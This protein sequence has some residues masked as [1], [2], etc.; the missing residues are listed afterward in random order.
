MSDSKTHI[1]EASPES[2]YGSW[3]INYADSPAATA[4]KH[5]GMDDNIKLNKIYICTEYNNYDV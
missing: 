5:E 2:V 1:G 3:S 4:S